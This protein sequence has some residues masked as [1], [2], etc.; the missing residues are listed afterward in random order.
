MTDIV[1]RLRAAGLERGFAIIL[2]QYVDQA[3]DEIER[4]QRL[5]Q[6]SY[7]DQH[8]EIERLRAHNQQLTVANTGF[9]TE[10]QRLRHQVEDRGQIIG[11]LHD[12]I[13]RLEAALREIAAD[14]PGDAWISEKAR[15]A[16]EGK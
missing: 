7:P 10:H 1:E 12:K 9:E 3:A 4:L 2:K 5:L 14:S 8:A 6:M 15:A 16:L 13:E 11:S